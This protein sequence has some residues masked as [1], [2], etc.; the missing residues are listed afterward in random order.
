MSKRAAGAGTPGGDC[1]PSRWVGIGLNWRSWAVAPPG[2]L[3]HLLKL[4]ARR[5][6]TGPEPSHPR[7][8][9]SSPSHALH[10]KAASGRA[11]CCPSTKAISRRW[12]SETYPR[13]WASFSKQCHSPLALR[14]YSLSASLGVSSIESEYTQVITK[15]LIR[16]GAR[17]VV[18]RLRNVTLP[19]SPATLHEFPPDTHPKHRAKSKTIRSPCWPRCRAVS[20][21]RRMSPAAR[22]RTVRARL[23]HNRDWID[24]TFIVVTLLLNRD[25]RPGRQTQGRWSLARRGFEM[26]SY[27]D[28][29]ST[30]LYRQTRRRRMFLEMHLPCLP[31]AP[32]AWPSLW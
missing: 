16:A 1:Q 23:Q 3:P 20:S 5:G 4:P 17:R 27:I 15:R 25:S 12:H 24:R 13:T 10:R 32:A 21:M 6:E 8:S 11:I 14:Q 30:G 19:W 22:E 31:S 28:I 2:H 18:G 7:R 29:H 26:P 9:I